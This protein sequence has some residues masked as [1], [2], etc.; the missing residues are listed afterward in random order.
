MEIERKFLPDPDR[1]PF[2]PQDFPCRHIEQGYLCTE[3]V[4]RI[5]RDNDDYFLTYKSKG[6]MVREEYN[7]P[8]DQKSYEHLKAKADGRIIVKNRYVIPLENGLFL[9]LDVFKGDLAPLVLAEIEFPD[10]SSARSYVPPE[11]LGKEVTHSAQYH[12]S[13]LSRKQV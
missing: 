2:H 6:L 5:R 10:E 1:L 4:V 9:E 7:L 13:T 12:N 8:L 11:W 3:P